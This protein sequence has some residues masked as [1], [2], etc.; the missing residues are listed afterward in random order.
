MASLQLHCSDSSCCQHKNAM[1]AGSVAIFKNTRNERQHASRV[2]RDA[3]VSEGP[4]G[5][6]TLNIQHT[7][8]QATFARASQGREHPSLQH[9][10]RQLLPP[11]SRHRPCLVLAPH[12]TQSQSMRLRSLQLLL[13]AQLVAVSALLLAAVDRARVQA[14][15]APKTGEWGRGVEVAW[16]RGQLVLPHRHNMEERVSRRACATHKMTHGL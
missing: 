14:G 3:A 10:P 7:W 8:V 4:L 15:I 11:N 13:G 5:T 6:S 9:T 2:Y 16:R 1:L 12:Y